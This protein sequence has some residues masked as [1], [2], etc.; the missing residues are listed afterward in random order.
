[1]GKRMKNNRKQVKLTIDPFGATRPSEGYEGDIGNTLSKDIGYTFVVLIVWIIEL[2]QGGRIEGSSFAAGSFLL[3]WST[4]FNRT[5]RPNND[6]VRR[7][8]IRRLK[9]QIA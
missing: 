8:W 7:I 2:G 1:M 5:P 3:S 6:A 9:L 4:G